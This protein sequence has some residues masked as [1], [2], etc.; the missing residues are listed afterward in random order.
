VIDGKGKVTWRFT[1]V[2]YKV[3]PTNEMVLE[4]LRKK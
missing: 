1:E 2:N 3:R 4:A